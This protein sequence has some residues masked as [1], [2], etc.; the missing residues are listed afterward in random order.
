MPRKRLPLL[1]RGAPGVAVA[2]ADLRHARALAVVGARDDPQPAAG[3]APARHPD[4]DLRPLVVEAHGARAA[5]VLLAARVDRDHLVGQ[6]AAGAQALAGNERVAR[7]LPHDLAAD[8]D[9]EALRAPQVEAGAPLELRP[10]LVRPRRCGRSPPAAR[11]AGRGRRPRACA[12]R[13]GRPGPSPRR[14]PRRGRRRS[15]TGRRRPAR[16]RAARA[17]TSFSNGFVG[18]GL[19]RP[20]IAPST[21]QAAITSR[22]SEEAGSGSESGAGG[23]VQ[24]L[25]GL[26]EVVVVERA[27]HATA[28]LERRQALPAAVDRDPRR[29]RGRAA[30]ERDGRVEGRAQH[31]PRDRARPAAEVLAEDGPGERAVVLDVDVDR[32]GA[33]AGLAAEV[34][35]RDAPA[36]TRR[37]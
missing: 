19:S 29:A 4:L 16:A 18:S 1:A 13:P 12:R 36:G 3:G 8:D 22:C 21:R 30:V 26:E 32:V 34:G 15:R 5:R 25:R 11:A 7:R 31:P 27:E 10:Q 17:S 23:E 2:D 37:D 35:Q 14:S 28:A 6:R 33:P 24:R 20:L 9:A